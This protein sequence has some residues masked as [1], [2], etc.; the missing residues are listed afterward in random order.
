MTLIRNQATTPQAIDAHIESPFPDSPGIPST[1]LPSPSS[2]HEA[3]FVADSPPNI[4]TF[5][6]LPD[7]ADSG[8]SESN[9]IPG[10][11]NAGPSTSTSEDVTTSVS[12]ANC[13]SYSLF[14]DTP[15]L[16]L[17]DDLTET[18]LNPWS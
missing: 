8:S 2:A 9:A 10:P 6:Q 5:G 18:A 17:S 14:D 15:Y 3:L 12:A 13:D 11:S 4:P 16:Q 1:G 7:L